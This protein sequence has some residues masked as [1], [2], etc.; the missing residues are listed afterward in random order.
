MC[1]HSAKVFAEQVEAESARAAEICCE[2]IE[3]AKPMP[4]VVWLPVCEDDNK[5]R[6]RGQMRL[7]RERRDYVSICQH[8]SAD[9]SRCQH[10]SAY[11]RIRPQTSAYVSMRQKRETLVVS[12]RSAIGC[13]DDFMPYLASICPVMNWNLEIGTLN[14]LASTSKLQSMLR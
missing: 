13:C 12:S 10:T 5:G 11:V 9:V 6:S 8:M 4:S 7:W 2:L 3:T 14:S 1:P